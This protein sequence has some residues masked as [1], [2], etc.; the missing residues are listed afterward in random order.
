MSISL[1]EFSGPWAGDLT[2][3]FRKA[4]SDF[5]R[6]ALSDGTISEAEFAE[7]ENR[8]ITCLRA[9]GLTTAGIN[10]GGS[11]EFGF[12]PE[13]GPDK[14]NRISDNCSASSGYDTVGSLYFAM[15]RNPQNLD[16]AKIA[17]ACLGRK[18]VVPRGY[19][20]SDYKRDV[21]TMAFPFSDP[22]EGREALEACSADPLGLLPKKLSARTS[23]PTGS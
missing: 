23:P 14:A 8:F 2:Y 15:R 19:D 3:A 22:D 12:P 21:P 20:A 6:N 1:P 7:V 18:G 17:A 11:L 16:E 10:P 13:M 9:G 5:E 4:S